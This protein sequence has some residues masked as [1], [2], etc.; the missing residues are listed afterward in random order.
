MMRTDRK[1]RRIVAAEIAIAVFYSH[2]P[3]AS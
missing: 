2:C 1:S 3:A